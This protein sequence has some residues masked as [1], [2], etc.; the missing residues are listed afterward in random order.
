MKLVVATIQPSKLE[1]VRAALAE[2]H[3][4]HVSKKPATQTPVQSGLREAS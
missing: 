2:A 3:L 1:A 4:L